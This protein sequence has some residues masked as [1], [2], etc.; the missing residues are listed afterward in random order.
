TPAYQQWG[1]K[2]AP[3]PGQRGGGGIVVVVVVAMTMAGKAATVPATN[4]ST[5]DCS[6]GAF[7]TAAPPPPCSVLVNAT[8]SFCSAFPMPD[9]STAPSLAAMAWHFISS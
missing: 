8:P 1:R 4:P 9:G 2:P 5:R 6:A 7:P 3:P